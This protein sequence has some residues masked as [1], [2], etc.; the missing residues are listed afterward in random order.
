MKIYKVLFV[1]IYTC[2]GTN[3]HTP[4]LFSWIYRWL[5]SWFG[6]A[7]KSQHIV[8]CSGQQIA[9]R[10]HLSFPICYVKL[11]TSPHPLC[12]GAVAK[13]C[14]QIQQYHVDWVKLKLNDIRLQVEWVRWQCFDLYTMVV[15]IRLARAGQKHR[16]FYRV[17]E[18]LHLLPWDCLLHHC[19]GHV[20]FSWIWMRKPQNH[21]RLLCLGPT[22]CRCCK[23]S[24]SRWKVL[25]KGMSEA[26]YRWISKVAWLYINFR[27]VFFVC[28]LH[29]CTYPWVF[30]SMAACSSSGRDI[31]S[32]AYIQSEWKAC[33]NEHWPDQVSASD[34]GYSVRWCT[35]L[36]SE[37]VVFGDSCVDMSWIL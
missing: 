11:F 33:D 26:F 35:L 8:R 34:L 10:K 37:Y 3:T 12:F 2:D 23:R 24:S 13:N 30:L 22:D 7:G 17:R 29:T 15:A 18:H 6:S 32:V 31:W 19:Y 27:N 20:S 14:R 1:K 5:E 36:Q 9:P 4:H 25:G 21:L 28:W 16:A